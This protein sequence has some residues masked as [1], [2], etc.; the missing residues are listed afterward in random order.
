MTESRI[1]E[2][3]HFVRER[4]EGRDSCLLKVFRDGSVRIIGPDVGGI[5]EECSDA[6][7][8]AIRFVESKG[9]V[10]REES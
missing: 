3:M 5:V 2:T 1:V 7:G 9:Y 8:R 10:R 6:R 4:P